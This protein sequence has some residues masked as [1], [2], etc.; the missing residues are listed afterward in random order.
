ME[1]LWSTHKDQKSWVVPLCVQV[2]LEGLQ[3]GMPKAE[4]KT[5]AVAFSRDAYHWIPHIFHPFPKSFPIF[6]KSSHHYHHSDPKSIIFSLV[7]MLIGCCKNCN[8]TVSFLSVAQC[9]PW[10]LEPWPQ[11]RLSIGL[12]FAMSIGYDWYASDVSDVSGSPS[13]EGHANLNIPSLPTFVFEFSRLLI[14][15]PHVVVQ[16]RAFDTCN[17]D[18]EDSYRSWCLLMLEIFV[19]TRG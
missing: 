2:L 17:E 5:R 12:Y 4:N 6:P 13:C 16:P 7:N 19:F 3:Q 15:G 10:E 8:E 1:A 18:N 14:W 9:A 11:K